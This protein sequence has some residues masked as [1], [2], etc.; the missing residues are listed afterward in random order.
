LAVV[1]SGVE[2]VFTSKPCDCEDVDTASSMIAE[3]EWRNG[4]EIDAV[5]LN[6][7]LEIAKALKFAYEIEARPRVS[8][9]VGAT[10]RRADVARASGYVWSAE[11]RQ[12]HYLK[13]RLVMA[14]CCRRDGGRRRLAAGARSRRPRRIL[15]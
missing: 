11:G 4:V 5:R 13:S 8:A 1:R 2:G 9:I 6:P 15:A 10:A 14:A 3:A 12:P 7:L